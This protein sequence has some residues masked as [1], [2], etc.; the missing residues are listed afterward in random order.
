MAEYTALAPLFT[1]IANAIR[2]KTG[3]TGAITAN[4]FPQ[5]INAIPTTGTIVTGRVKSTAVTY[6]PATF[7]IPQ[8]IGCN[9]AILLREEA[10]GIT[11]T[12]FT[13]TVLSVFAVEGVPFYGYIFSLYENANIVYSQLSKIY[14]Y[15]DK[16][17]GEIGMTGRY[18][19]DY[20]YIQIPNNS[21]YRYIGW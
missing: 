4:Q 16:N 9:N 10:Y 20:G 8:L 17:T 13:D 15:Y 18:H 14:T 12:A 6:N 3:E 7:V 5:E 19:S 21:T 1:D 2:S 11:L